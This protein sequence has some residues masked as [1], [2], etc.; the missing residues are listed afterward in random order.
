[1]PFAFRSHRARAALIVALATCTFTTA[2]HAQDTV[3]LQIQARDRVQGTLR[4]VAERESFLIPMIE[5]DQVTAT[6]KRLGRD[7]PVPRLELLNGDLASVTEPTL[8]SRGAKLRKFEVPG[9]DD[10]RLRVSG[11]GVLD[12]DYDLSV[13]VKSKKRWVGTADEE[14]APQGTTTFDFSAPVGAEVTIT[15]Q[16]KGGGDFV[17]HVTSVTGPGG[18]DRDYQTDGGR[19]HVVGP[20]TIDTAGRYTAELR[21]DGT[22]PGLWKVV[23]KVKHRKLIRRTIDLRDEALTGEFDDEQPVFGRLV[24]SEGGLVDPPDDGSSIDG[25][26]LDVPA[27]AL[28]VPTILTVAEANEFFVDDDTF[29]SGLSVSLGPSGTI[30][31]TPINVTLP[32]DAQGFDDPLDELQIFVTN[33]ETEEL[34]LI[35]GP[36]TFGD[37]SVT[38]PVSHFSGFQ[39]TSTRPR[40]FRGEYVEL[41]VA[42]V[43]QTGF[44]VSVRFALNELSGQT[45]PRTGNVFGRTVDRRDFAFGSPA[46]GQ[47]QGGLTRTQEATN[48]T[49]TLGGQ[50]Q[51][52]L[53][54]ATIGARTLFRGRS[55]Q[56]LNAPGIGPDEAGVLLALRRTNGRP[57]AKTL[58]G[59]WRFVVWEFATERLPDGSGRITET[60]QTGLLDFK[61]N[62]DV[63]AKETTTVAKTAPYP[64]GAWQTQSDK[65]RPPVGRFEIDGR[66]VQFTMSLGSA[67]ELTD[68]KLI[69]TAKGAVMVGVA[70]VVQGPS[71]NT[72]RFASRMVLLMRTDPGVPPTKLAGARYRFFGLTHEHVSA[73]TVSALP[74]RIVTEQQS[75]DLVHDGEI[76]RILGQRRRLV[77]NPTGRVDEVVTPE[78]RRVPYRFDKR[79]AYRQAQ[80]PSPGILVRGGALLVLPSFGPDGI[81]LGFGL[82]AR[83]LEQ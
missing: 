76:V 35:P 28:D 2:L 4:P 67:P 1:M 5:G 15:F 27:G 33:Q 78:D 58:F 70:G 24:G 16:R 82:R 68:V 20:I 19:K 50:D 54:D 53:E 44:G 52:R 42:T 8:T 59:E 74:T 7:G 83:P 81:S 71:N 18:F 32:F 30:F 26:I 9:A 29:A 63:R 69:P 38:F 60:G 80:A 66:D 14:L 75:L 11:D 65:A 23:C 39:P 31:N 47:F 77:P 36:Y 40:P 61:P 25:A 49:A 79:G 57:T 62:G 3:D 21:N 55:R 73:A 12:G 22:E 48:G 6:L 10:F 64:R 51:V 45:G 46:A 72:N 56:F 41:E 34:E 37:D 43:H 17:P 13:K